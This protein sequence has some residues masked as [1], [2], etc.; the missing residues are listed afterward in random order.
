[1]DTLSPNDPKASTNES[2][3]SLSRVIPG[4]DIPSSSP[5]AFIPTPDPSSVPR[6]LV[7]TVDEASACDTLPSSRTTT[8]P[9]LFGP[10]DDHDTWHGDAQNSV[11]DLY[12]TVIGGNIP[13]VPLNDPDDDY[14]FDFDDLYADGFPRSIDDLHSSPLSDDDLIQAYLDGLEPCHMAL[15]RM[16]VCVHSLGQT[17]ETIYNEYAEDLVARHCAHADGGSMV[18][19]THIQEHLWHYQAHLDHHVLLRVA[20]DHGHSPIGMGYLKIPVSGTLG[21]I[22]F[23]CYYTPTM[24]ATIISPDA[25]GRSLGCQGYQSV[26]NFDGHD[27]G[28]RL[29][30]P[31]GTTKDITIPLTLVRGLL[32]TDHIITPNNADDR[33]LPYP[34]SPIHATTFVPDLPDTTTSETTCRSPLDDHLDLD[35]VRQVQ[36]CGYQH[37]VDYHALPIACDGVSVFPTPSCPNCS[38]LSSTSQVTLPTSN[39][40]GST[41][42]DCALVPNIFQVCHLG[43]DQLRL[44]WHQRLGHLN[45]RR[46]S[47][48]HRTATGV[49]K[50][51]NADDLDNCPI[52]LAAKLKRAARGQ[53][54]SRSATL[55]NQGLSIDTGF[56]VQRSNDSDRFLRSVGLNSETC[57]CLITDHHSGT[58]YGQCFASKLPPLDFL[59]QWLATHGQP[60]DVPNKYV[61]LDQGGELAGCHA[62]LTLFANAGYHVQVTATDTSS[63]NGPVERP[64][65]TISNAIMTM[66]NGAN[67]PTKF[68]PYAFHH[69][70]RLYNVTPHA[71]AAVSPME[72]C[73]GRRPDLSL[74]RTFGCR[75]YALPPR[76]QHRRAEKLHPDSRRGVFLGYA[77]TFKNALY[78][79]ETTETVKICQHIAF[80]ETMS[81]LPFADRSPNAKMLQDLKDGANLDSLNMAA[82]T[83]LIDLDVNVHPFTELKTIIM[84]MDVDQ[85]HPLHLEVADCSD[86]GRAFITKLTRPA[87]GRRTLRA[88]QN[89]TIGAYVVA[90][91]GQPVFTG[92]EV[93]DLIDKLSLTAT[94][95]TNVEILIAPERHQCRNDRLPPV[96]LRVADLRRVHALQEVSGQGA[97]TAQY[98]AL[99]EAFDADPTD[100]GLDQFIPIL[101]DATTPD[102]YVQFRVCRLQSDGM[103][104]EERALPKFTRKALKTLPNWADWDEAHDRQL[105]AHHAAGTLGAPVPRPGQRPDGS[106]PNVF[107]TVWTNIIKTDGI[108]KSRSC[109][110]GSVRAAPQLRQS[111]QTYS[112][113]IEHPCQ[114]LFFALAASTGKIITYAD[115]ANAFQQSPPPSEQCYL[116]I[117]DAYSSWYS[118]RFGILLDRRT[119]VIPLERALQGHPEAGVLWEKLIVG[120][121]E[122]PDLHFASTT[123]ERNLYHGT[124]LGEKV[125]ICR[126]VDDFAVASDTTTTAE[127]IIALINSHVTTESKGIGTVSPDG[128]HARYNGVDVR[129]TRHYVKLSCD[130]YIHRMLQSHGWETPAVHDSDR[131]DSVPMSSDLAQ[132]LQ[133]LSGPP[134][135]T[136]EHLAIERQAGFSYRQVLGELMYA[137]VICRVDIGF[138]ATMLARFSQNPC[139]E[140]YHA[141]KHVVKYL[142]RTVDWGLMYWRT[143]PRLDLPDVAFV[144]V[145]PDPA[146]PLFPLV[147]PTQLAGFVDASHAPELAARRSVTG[148]DFTYA[149]C[150]VAYKSKVQPT[151]STSSTEAEF[152]A[153]VF[154]A[155]TAKYLRS[156]LTELGYP[157]D[158][159]TPLFVDNQAAIAMVNEDRPTPRARHIDIQWFAIQQ[160]RRSGLIKLTHIPGILNPADQNTKAL[161]TTLHHRHARRLMGHYGCPNSALR[162]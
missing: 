91:N 127:A 8:V 153:C 135:H 119:H 73:T 30:H 132:H 39:L 105:D 65:Q 160:W 33:S 139:M 37:D 108:R 47:D 63:S 86:Y 149:G 118:K 141:L 70:L 112:S 26:S 87:V 140:H 133:T 42:P 2:V 46:T 25:I 45:F 59:N 35:F 49:P 109:L 161:D 96:H 93:R 67:L 129:Q 99:L 15:H 10:I 103:T 38:G 156:V 22:M 157:P 80:D 83:Q 79:D 20:D 62:V 145:A 13:M 97:T 134:E 106:R 9:D 32:Y 98:K 100:E 61:R 120:I 72:I 54:D 95:P 19:T 43:R 143:T 14:D 23:P 27:C 114:R 142:R 121:L 92:A 75:I 122:G 64:H 66:L 89:E 137:Y 5:S 162:D 151:V 147:D 28:I 48:L 58:L 55:C 4:D 53:A 117:D 11:C 136:P 113:C 107:R 150:T 124:F 50:I 74:L 125:I 57:Y 152:I 16:S 21:S 115:T 154:A 126:Q 155:K 116:E 144:P 138:A 69:Y 94:P 131:Y 12:D 81:D 17:R 104:P 18:S 111:T 51:A 78:F 1:L 110:D 90:I 130:T 40:S 31:A 102:P 82:P 159:P 52:C 60:R 36:R 24:P 3:N 146:L 6:P 77:Q 44:L 71:D 56:I 88:F 101:V 29:L 84:P 148:L 68:W 128:V 76:P 34:I 7:E 123:H 158:G 41:M 85:P